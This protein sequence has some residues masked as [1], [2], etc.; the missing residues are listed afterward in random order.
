M[1]END[2][3]KIV[4][5]EEIYLKYKKFILD[6]EIMTSNDKKYCPI[7]NCDNIIQQKPN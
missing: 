3:E 6:Y 1:S 5:S 4:K 7:P 2:I